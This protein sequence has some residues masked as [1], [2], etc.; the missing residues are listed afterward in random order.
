M[1]QIA[2]RPLQTMA[3]ILFIAA[4]GFAQ[5]N[6]PQPQG[7][8]NDFA[9]RLSPATTQRL[10][11]QLKNFSDQHGIEIAVVLMS[12]DDLQNHSIEKYTRELAQRWKNNLAHQKLQLVLLVAIK[13]P[14]RKG[15]YSGSTRLEVSRNLEKVMPDALAGEIIRSIRED[16]KA[17]RF[18]KALTDGVQR[19]LATLTT[20]Y[21]PAHG[22]VGLQSGMTAPVTESQAG[23]WSFSSVLLLVFGLPLFII[24]VV[25][26][27]LVRSVSGYK[28]NGKYQRR[29]DSRDGAGSDSNTYDS[30]SN[31]YWHNS[32]FSDSSDN[33]TFS[34]SSSNSDWSDSSSSSSSSDSCSSSSDSDGGGSTDSW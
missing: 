29:N 27:F 17:G 25:A 12:W 30:T 26:F 9:K 2:K 3:I 22:N 20:T 15:V 13:K 34:D 10:E 18:D 23:K 33:S 6:I 11:V 28:G 14:N 16:F 31:S 19:I 5:M 8:V 1:M 32:S 21:E 24:A 4:T 7:L